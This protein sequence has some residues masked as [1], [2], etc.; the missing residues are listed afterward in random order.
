MAVLELVKAPDPRLKLVSQPVAD[1]D[2]ALRRFMDDMVETMYAE[3]GIGLA[4]I[5]V[6]VPKRVA[7]IDLDPGGPNSKQ[8]YIVNPRIVEASDELSTFHEGCLS[9]PEVWDDVKRPARLSVEYTDEH[10][11][12][13]TVT[14]DGLFATCLQHEIDHLNGRL[15]IDHLSKLK[16]SIA[17]RKSAKLKRQG[18]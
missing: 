4:A 7:V 8:L 3:N 14:A 2:K 17:L 9:V 5:Q 1:V 10:G 12:K 11:A 15:F 16:R 13:Q 18:E 6:G